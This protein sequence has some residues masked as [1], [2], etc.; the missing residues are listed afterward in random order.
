MLTPA[1][2]RQSAKSVRKNVRQKSQIPSQ[3]ALLEVLKGTETR[4]Q[5][6]G[7]LRYKGSGHPLWFVAEMERNVYL[8]RN[9]HSLAEQE[10]FEFW[11]DAPRLIEKRLGT[12]ERATAENPFTNP[13][14][15][16][17]PEPGDPEHE[18]EYLRSLRT[19]L[20]TLQ[21]HLHGLSLIVSCVSAD[22]HEEQRE[23]VV[24]PTPPAVTSTT[25]ALLW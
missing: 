25:A 20:H 24:L 9:G 19:T 5:E 21:L 8:W 10:R 15:G 2:P 3:A 13:L 6:R 23:A 4:L 22:V 18:Q 7:L 1:T 16:L 14:W 17:S 11:I 12:L